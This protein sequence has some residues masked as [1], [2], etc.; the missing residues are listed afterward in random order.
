METWETLLFKIQYILL[1]LS[2]IIFARA[3]F[4]LPES[5]NICHRPGENAKNI[6]REE[7]AEKYDASGEKK[8]ERKA[9]ILVYNDFSGRRLQRKKRFG[10]GERKVRPTNEWQVGVLK[11]FQAA[12]TV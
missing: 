5:V 4:R 10:S 6:F 1:S 3:H 12:Y 7:C 9:L 8:R 2:S 11:L